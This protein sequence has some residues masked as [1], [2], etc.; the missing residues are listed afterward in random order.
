MDW[1][2]AMPEGADMNLPSPKKNNKNVV[3]S[4]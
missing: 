2:E 1:R 3:V 4:G